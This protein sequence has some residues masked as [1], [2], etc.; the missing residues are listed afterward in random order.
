MPFFVVSREPPGA[1][2]PAAERGD[3]GAA[4]VTG[5]RSYAGTRL[6]VELVGFA[7]LIVLARLIAP[8]EFGVAAIALIVP[9]IAEILSYEGFGSYL[10]RRKDATYEDAGAV[11]SLCLLFCAVTCLIF[12]VSAPLTGGLFGERAS[13]LIALSSLSFLV[14]GPGITPLALLQRNLDFKTLSLNEAQSTV[15]GAAVSIALAATGVGAESL[16]V[17]QLVR[18]GYSTIA[19]Q[20]AT[21]LVLPRW[22][23][24]TMRDVLRNGGLAAISGLLFIGKNNADYVILGARLGAVDVGYYYRAYALGIQYQS[25]IG[26][27]LL[28]VAFPTYARARDEADMFHIRKRFARAQ[29]AVTLPLLGVFVATAPLLVPFVFGDRWAPSAVPAQILSITAAVLLVTNGTGPMI[30]ATGRTAYLAVSNLLSLVG[31]ALV[32]YFASSGGLIAACWGVSAFN[33]GFAAV[34]T[35]V[36]VQVMMRQPVIELLKEL[37]VP[38]V[39]IMPTIVAGL[40]LIP[41]NDET[42]AAM[43]AALILVT[44]L[45]GIASY[46]ALY[47]TFFRESW[48]DVASMGRRFRGGKAKRVSATGDADTL[49]DPPTG[50]GTPPT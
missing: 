9:Q 46:A 43:E 12:T 15:L 10:V 35:F 27:V 26:M 39:C 24:K 19:A 7:S 30:L 50:R 11:S 22:N 29:M 14:A 32:V 17:G 31:F 37:L 5:A 16:I 18:R 41:S 47:R 13:N 21:E 3:V 28:R 45:A 36:F 2:L 40:L 44:T 6:V 25:K 42:S 38:A 49:V 34:Q 4:A 33:V 1:R 48:E 23:P 20:A 8:D